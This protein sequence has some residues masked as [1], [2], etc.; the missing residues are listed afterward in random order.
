MVYIQLLTYFVIVSIPRAKQKKTQ[1]YQTAYPGEGCNLIPEAKR[2]PIPI[3]RTLCVDVCFSNSSDPN[4]E[5]Q[6]VR[7]PEILITAGAE[8]GQSQK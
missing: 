8:R 3:H 5:D 2:R 4:R 1:K 6:L 7:D